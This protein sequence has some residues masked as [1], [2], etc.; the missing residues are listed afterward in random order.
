MAAAPA[1]SREAAA[2]ARSA[3]APLTGYTVA[4]TAQRRA[5]ELATLL[6]RRGARTTRRCARRR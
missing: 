6:E 1:P 5:D 2:E 3:L 4:V